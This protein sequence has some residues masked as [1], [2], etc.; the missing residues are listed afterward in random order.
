MKA[1]QL[2][3][4]VATL[5]IGIVVIKNLWLGGFCCKQRGVQMERTFG[6]IKPEATATGKAGKIID[7]I[8]SEGFVIVG[9]KK[10]QMTKALA[11]QFYAVHKEKPFFGELV[12]SVTSGPIIALVL[13]KNGAIL[14]WR[15]LMGATNPEKAAE[16]TLRKLYGTSMTNNATHGSDAPETAASEIALVFPELK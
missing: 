15:E 11:E 16:G 4:L 14:A 9:M 5:G 3:L 12:Q 6:M 7:R 13:E 10:M 8:E 1:T 2:I